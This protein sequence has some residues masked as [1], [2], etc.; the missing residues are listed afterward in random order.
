APKQRPEGTRR[1]S[2]LSARVTPQ[3][4][5]GPPSNLLDPPACA[6]FVSETRGAMAAADS[7]MIVVSAVS[8]VAVGT[9]RVWNSSLE[10]ELSTM[11]VV[12]KMDR[13]NADFFRTMAEIESTLAGNLA[14]I[15]VPIGQ[16]ESFRGIVDLLTMQAYEW[17]DGEPRPVPL[18]DEVAGIAREYRDRL[19]EAIV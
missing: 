8:G 13:E 18:P 17:P 16:A 19:V 4:R 6:D 11:V 3:T 7:A 10:R 12:N 2:S 14:A 9:E 15:Q 5:Q 1:T